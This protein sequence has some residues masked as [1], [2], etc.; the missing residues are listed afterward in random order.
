[1]RQADVQFIADHLRGGTQASQQ[2]IFAVGGPASQN[3]SVCADRGKGQNVQDPDIDVADDERLDRHP[4]NVQGHVGTER[5]DR[6][7]DHGHEHR[8]HRRQ[9]E[10]GLVGSGRDDVFFEEQFQSVGD[11]LEN[12][13]RA[14]FHRA[15]SILH[16]AEHFP[17][18]IGQG[19]DRDHYNAHLCQYLGE[20]NRKPQA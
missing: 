7:S 12:S 16:P 10:Q 4:K 19:R 5:D 8:Q 13:I 3:N 11:R 15:H 20:R 18:E 6:K 17:L 2:G 1:M 14:D 9:G